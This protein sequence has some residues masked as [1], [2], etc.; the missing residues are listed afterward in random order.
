MRCRAT[1]LTNSL[2]VDGNWEKAPWQA[3]TPLLIGRY[4]GEQPSHYPKTQVK[5]AYD[6]AAIYVIFRVEDRYVRAVA[7]EHDGKVWRDSCV[8]F[9]F[10]PGRDVARGYFN[11]EM[12]CGGTMLLHFQESPGNNCVHIPTN[13]CS[14]IQVAHSLPKIVDPEIQ[15]PVTWMVEYRLPLAVVER[16]CQVDQPARGTA[17]HVNFYKCGDDTSH[18]HWLSWS[19][20]EVQPPDFHRPE[21]F[22]VLEFQ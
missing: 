10:T 3:I 8:E 12:N 20:V 22:G 6:D 13:E 2:A 18:P 14:A 21:F 1:R 4:V 7:A 17:W 9:F 16:Y 15:Q 11:L 5:I 19:P